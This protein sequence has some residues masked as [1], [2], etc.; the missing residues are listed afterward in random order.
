MDIRK[1]YI[2]YLL[3]M[4]M[5]L[6]S[7]TDP[8]EETT[9]TAYEELPISLLLESEPE[10][11]SM[12]VEL[13]RHADMYNTLNLKSTYTVFAPT[14]EGV[15]RYL[16]ANGWSSVTD[17]PKEDASYLVKYHTINLV[18]IGQSQFENGVIND[19]NAT[20]DNLSIEFREG[21]LNAIYLNGESRIVELDIEATNGIIHG[22]EDVLVPV[23][24]T[25]MDRLG[26]E[27]FSIFREAVEATGRAEMLNTIVEEETDISGNPLE[28]RIRMT[29][30][31]VSDEVFSQAGI[32]SLADL[33]AK[34]EV[35][36]NDYTSEESGLR[37][38]VD[39]HLL[40]QVRSF[41]DLGKFPEG[42]TSMNINTLAT[43]E[44]INIA[45]RSGSLVMNYDTAA[46]KGVEFIEENINCKNGV[47]HEVDHWMPLFTP[48]R[49]TVIWDLTDYADLQALCDQYQNSSL[50]STYTRTFTQEELTCY[51]WKSTPEY[52]TNAV[53]Y[54]NNRGADGIWYADAVNHDHLR[55][56]L[57][58]SGW[59]EMETPVLIKGSYEI[60]MTYLSYTE[61]ENTGYLQ[62]SMDGKRLGSQWPVS[63][64]RYD[65][66]L[67]RRM[68]SSFTFDETGSH[69]LRIVAIDGELLTLDHIR[70]KPV[71]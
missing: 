54:R 38:Y 53:A 28:Y 52:R 9:F 68:T 4:V 8:Y 39:Y 1:N 47:M 25:I 42:E 64:R 66:A 71:D 19:R 12:W 14:N 17:I 55:L 49:V 44:L 5:A 50:N 48:E 57:G 45:D 43:N 30:F 26:E 58:Q 11:F 51:T 70:F 62:C 36:D 69:T 56:D 59:I 35:E 6:A 32:T 34:L 2:I 41:A 33:I 21:G 61:R 46:H 16:D 63:N 7:C 23:R 27:R 40:S 31:A 20:D 10:K 37:K 29:A 22:L 24:A 3:G 13:M 60:T 15:E 18:K 67:E 65:R